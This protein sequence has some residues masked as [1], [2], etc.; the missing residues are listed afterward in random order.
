MALCDT[1]VRRTELDEVGAMLNKACQ[2]GNAQSMIVKMTQLCED[3]TL[4]AKGMDAGVRHWDEN[5]RPAVQ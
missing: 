1:A 4:E 2:V 3:N 5:P